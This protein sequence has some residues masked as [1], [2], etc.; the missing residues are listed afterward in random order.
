MFFSLSLFSH[1]TVLQTQNFMSSLNGA[2]L[3]T[4]VIDNRRYKSRA[5]PPEEK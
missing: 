2:I 1:D 3:D 5:M 4:I